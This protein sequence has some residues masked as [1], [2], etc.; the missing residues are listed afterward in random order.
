MKY[1]KCSDDEAASP[2]V[3]HARGALFQIQRQLGCRGASALV[4]SHAMALVCID[5]RS[6]VLFALC[7]LCALCDVGTGRSTSFGLRGIDSAGSGSI[8]IDPVHER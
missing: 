1:N 2:V 4:L 5:M 7:E 8:M 6:C 3:R